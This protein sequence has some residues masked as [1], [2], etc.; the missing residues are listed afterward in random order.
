[1]KETLSSFMKSVG[2]AVDGFVFALKTQSHMRFHLFA[3]ICVVSLGLFLQI[4]SSEWLFLSLA[5]AMVW[6]CELF[7]TALETLCDEVTEEYSKRIKV[8]KDLG[9]A[10]TLVASGFAVIVGCM[11]FLP[12]LKEAVLSHWF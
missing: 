2:N 3:A 12:K 5:V 6:I 1:M 9:A 8:S 7:N 10:A 4:S 11:I